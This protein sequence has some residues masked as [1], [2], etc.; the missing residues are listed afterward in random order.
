M[1]IAP[2]HPGEFDMVLQNAEGTKKQIYF[3]NPEIVQNNPI[4]DEL[5][6]LAV[7]IEENSTPPVPLEQGAQA[8]DVALRVIDAFTAQRGRA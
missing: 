7:A 8:L 3:E 2:E 5:E 6:A 4:L 1:N